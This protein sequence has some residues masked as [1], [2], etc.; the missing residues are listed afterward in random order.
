MRAI[1]AQVQALGARVLAVTQAGPPILKAFLAEEALP[2][3]L[4]GDPN[5]RAYQAFGL[6][7]LSWLA[8]LRP[9]V[10]LGY[11]RLI[12]RGWRPRRGGTGEDVRQ[13]GGDFVLG[14]AGRLCWVFRGRE[15]TDR[16]GMDELLRALGGCGETPTPA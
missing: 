12:F 16:P 4:V 7:R 3:P 1:H 13:G 15:P 2:F 11:L 6:E 10:I 9:R 8:I 14:A 5:R